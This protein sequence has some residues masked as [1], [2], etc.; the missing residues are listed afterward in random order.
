MV[1]AAAFLVIEARG[2]QGEDYS[3]DGAFDVP[4]H[5]DWSFGVP[6]MD[7]FWCIYGV[8]FVTDPPLLL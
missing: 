6:E 1:Q 3:R 2:S 8:R 4:H 7:G 5:D